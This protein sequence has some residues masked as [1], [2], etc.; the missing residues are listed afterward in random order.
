MY[1]VSVGD[2][3]T[4]SWFF[5]ILL[6]PRNIGQ[7]SVVMNSE[8]TLSQGPNTQAL[9]QKTNLSKSYSKSMTIM[10]LNALQSWSSVC[11]NY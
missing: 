9:I 7:D 10:H 8:V 2:L 3:P 11:D 1:A 4:H 5:N 6:L